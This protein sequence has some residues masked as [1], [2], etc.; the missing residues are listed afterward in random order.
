[1][2]I[3]KAR[4]FYQIFQLSAPVGKL[5]ILPVTVLRLVAVCSTPRAVEILDEGDN[6][7]N[8]MDTVQWDHHVALLGLCSLGLQP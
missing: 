3:E 5:H 8:K 7:T 2:R 1:M 6:A 4:G